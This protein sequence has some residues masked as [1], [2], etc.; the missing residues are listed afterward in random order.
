MDLRNDNKHKDMLSPKLLDFQAKSKI[1]VILMLPCRAYLLLNFVFSAIV[2]AKLQFLNGFCSYFC[3][4]SMKYV[5]KSI[6]ERL[7]NEKISIVMK[8]TIVFTG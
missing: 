5:Q 6:L 4:I 2:C 7:L 3:E 1:N 8:S